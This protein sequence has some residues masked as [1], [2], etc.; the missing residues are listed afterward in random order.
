MALSLFSADFLYTCTA[1]SCWIVMNSSPRSSSTVMPNPPYGVTSP[2]LGETF[3][4][5]VRENTYMPG[6]ESLLTM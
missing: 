3:P 2:R 1:P 5:A 4:L 6:S